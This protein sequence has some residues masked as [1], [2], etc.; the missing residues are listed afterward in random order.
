MD[1][2]TQQEK[3]LMN[4]VVQK[5]QTLHRQLKTSQEQNSLL[6]QQVDRLH[7][8]AAVGMAW[9]M[10]AHEIN[11]LLTPLTSYAQFALAHPEDAK[12]TE[13]A[14]NKAILLTKKTTEMLERVM[15]LAGQKDM[16]GR[17]F[18]VKSLVEDVF[19]CICRDFRKDN[20]DVDVQTPEDVVIFSDGPAIRQVLMNLILNA[21]QAMLGKGGE[22]R[23]RA[24][25]TTEAVWIE[26]T[27]T[28][29]GIPPATMRKIFDPFYSTKSDVVG[30]DGPNNGIGLAFC[31]QIIEKHDGMISVES[32][33]GHGTCFK[34]RLPR[35]NKP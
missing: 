30:P 23:V 34:I 15:T 24:Y 26:I 6:S 11:N 5:R 1:S 25:Q 27:D 35:Q 7:S 12:L 17:D 18:T 33:T 29:G 22:L 8:L 9:T 20:I 14:M 28:G 3:A 4:G 32:Q 16:E 31:K 19:A 2:S 10:T 21:R 13:K